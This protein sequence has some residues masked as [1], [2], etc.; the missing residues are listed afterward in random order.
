[1]RVAPE[2]LPATGAEVESREQDIL[3]SSRGWRRPL[4]LKAYT[5]AGTYPDLYCY[6][7]AADATSEV[8]HWAMRAFTAYPMDIGGLPAHGIRG[9]VIVVRAN[10]PTSI[11]GPDGDVEDL[12]V[13]EGGAFNP[14][15][16]VEEMRDTLLFY[17]TRDATAI[18]RERDMQRTMR[19]VPPEMAAM[20]GG[21]RDLGVFTMP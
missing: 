3:Q 10:P 16:R 2:P 4:G 7:D 6:F 8:N 14:T 1:M 15:I 5:K 9:N 12:G 17:G 21:I 13:A 20:M 18:A 19:G 11:S